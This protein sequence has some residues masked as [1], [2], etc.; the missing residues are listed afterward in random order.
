MLELWSCNSFLF[1]GNIGAVS[2]ETDLNH[3]SQL[4]RFLEVWSCIQWCKVQIVKV[5][6]DAAIVTLSQFFNF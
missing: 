2:P 3:H 5:I 4:I 1:Y 6:S